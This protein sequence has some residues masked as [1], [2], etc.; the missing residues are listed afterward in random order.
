MATGTKTRPFLRLLEASGCP[1]YV[2]GPN[3][4]LVFLSAGCADWLGL[5]VEQLLERRCVAGS[6]ISDDPL[7][8]LA[9]SLSPPAGL[10]SRGTASLRIQPPARGEIRPESIEVRFT[11]VGNSSEAL[12]VAVGGHFD[13]REIDQDL[14]DAVA[15]RGQ[16]D[17]WRKHH[18]D[19][20]S[21]ATAGQSA[22]LRRMRRRL[23]VAASTRTDFGLFGPRGCGS[24]S[25]ARAVHQASCPNEPLIAVDGPLMDTELLDAVLMP[26]IRPLTESRQTKATALIRGC[27]EMPP[28]AQQRLNDVWQTFDGRLRLISLCR[29]QPMLIKPSREP[30]PSTQTLMLDEV[31]PE[32]LCSELWE[33]VAALTIVMEPLADRVE[34][35]P[36]V[37]TAILEKRH[38]L[39]EG[40]A[41]RFSRSA[42]DALVLYPW[43]GDYQELDEAIRH[44]IAAARGEIIGIE[45]LPLA[46]RSFRPGQGSVASK[47]RNISLDDALNR[48]EL[49]MIQQALEASGGNRAEAARRLGISRARLLRRI[50][51]AND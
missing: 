37:A 1:L 20:A 16:L 44:A 17:R 23:R 5:D 38:A 43:P 40:G 46:V 28:E 31:S 15:L 22:A 24:E 13:D 3:G 18:T 2:I 25:V 29:L 47:R 9:A 7:D 35:I 4:K 19:L 21:I 6:P 26:V 41:E 33:I 12:I 30:S 48:F 45:H 36:H 32:G 39:G 34:D 49:R 8:R 50:D 42:L 27:D 11:R 51:T 10:A 14:R